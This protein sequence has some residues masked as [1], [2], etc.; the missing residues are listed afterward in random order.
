G[1]PPGVLGPDVADPPGPGVA[2]R[3]AVAPP[4]VRGCPDGVPGGPSRRRG[5]GAARAG[6][7][8]G[9]I[10]TTSE[11][12]ASFATCCRTARHAPALARPASP[13]DQ[14]P[15]GVSPPAHAG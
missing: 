12:A 3:H 14:P 4:R 10:H 13:A 8:T 11:S 9:R 5:V 7:L 6:D 2:R 15:A 1:R